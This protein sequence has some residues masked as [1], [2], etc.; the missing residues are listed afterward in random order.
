VQRKL[1]ESK[2]YTKEKI[3]IEFINQIVRN[4]QSVLNYK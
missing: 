4:K 1:G 2:M 3:S